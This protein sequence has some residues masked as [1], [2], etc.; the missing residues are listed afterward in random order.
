MLIKMK[1]VQNQ[2]AETQDVRCGGGATAALFQVVYPHNAATVTEPA[3]CTCKVRVSFGILWCSFKV[4][5]KLS[6]PLV[7]DHLWV[8]RSVPYCLAWKLSTWHDPGWE[9]STHVK[10]PVA[11]CETV[12]VR[13]NEGEHG[14]SLPCLSGWPWVRDRCSVGVEPVLSTGQTV[15]FPGMSL[16]S[17]DSASLMVLPVA[18]GDKKESSS[19]K[20]D[21][22]QVL[23]TGNFWLDTSQATSLGTEQMV[24]NL[25]QWVPS[26]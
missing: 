26:K 20:L 13:G 22:G 9:T 19:D 11:G 16:L 17:S 4:S 25:G 24:L 15:V 23:L 2:K 5:L 18:W 14:L 12:A 21:S 10:E 1:E 6:V 7:W 8:H 3:S